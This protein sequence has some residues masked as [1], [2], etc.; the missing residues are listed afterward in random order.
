MPSVRVGEDGLT[1]Y[2]VRIGRA[3][4]G[5][6]LVASAVVQN[7]DDLL[8]RVNEN[9]LDGL[10]LQ[11]SPFGFQRK[12]IPLSLA[13]KLRMLRRH[14]GRRHLMCHELWLGLERG[15]RLKFRLWGALQRMAIRRCIRAWQPEKVHTQC[16]VYANALR[17]IGVNAGVL[18]LPGNVP[19]S[20]PNDAPGGESHWPDDEEGSPPW[21]RVI[22]FGRVHP[23][24]D[25]DESVQGLSAKANASGMRLALLFAGRSY[26]HGE[27]VPALALKFSE[28]WVS[29]T[30]PVAAERLSGLFQQ[31]HWGLA[32]TPWQLLAK[33]GSVAALR[34]HG[35]PV[36]VARD[37]FR[38]RYF[39]DADNGREGCFLLSDRSGVSVGLGRLPSSRPDVRNICRQFLEEWGV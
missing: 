11:F 18:P 12:G 10:S 5:D 15:S 9:G 14:C 21:L 36:W 22:H 35:L 20:D 31:A 13:P 38:C 27:I 19:V 30:G 24:L 1:D 7:L 23:D 2:A 37:D 33:S 16:S 25:L 3:L 26:L 29:E 39:D 34:E 17:A 32:G 28:A 4:Q 6:G 8:A